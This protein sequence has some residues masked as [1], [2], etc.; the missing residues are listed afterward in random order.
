MLIYLSLL[1]Y[2]QYQQCNYK[3]S[4]ITKQEIIV[5]SSQLVKQKILKKKNNNNKV[6]NHMLGVEFVF[7][8]VEFYQ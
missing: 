8:I 5:G 3:A 2:Q 4:T 1:H 7:S 6:A